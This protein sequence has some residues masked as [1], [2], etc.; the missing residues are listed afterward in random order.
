MNNDIQNNQVTEDT[1]IIPQTPTDY[2][3]PKDQQMMTQKLETVNADQ[4]ASNIPA[5]PAP[6]VETQ[7]IPSPPSAPSIDD[8]NVVA[9]INTTT[10]A[11]PTMDLSHVDLN[12]N[13]NAQSLDLT[14]QSGTKEGITMTGKT[15]TKKKVKLV[16]I[17]II[18]VLILGLTGGG[19]YFYISQFKSYDKR[20]DAVVDRAFTS[21]NNTTNYKI[22]DGSGNYTFSYN[23]SKNEDLFVLEANG[24]YA[25]NLP[26]KQVDLITN[27]TK[28]TDNQDLLPSE[29]QTEIYLKNNQ[30]Y[31]LSDFNNSYIY[32]DINESYN[33]IQD[34][35]SRF[36]SPEELLL[37]KVTNLLFESGLKD[38]S[39]N[40]DTYITNISK[41]ENVDYK[42]IINGVK[43]ATKTA[44]KSAPITQSLE[45]T[46]NVVTISIK[47]VENQ[48]KVDKA[49]VEALHNNSKAFEQLV[50]ITGIEDGKLYKELID[51]LEKKE[52]KELANNIVIKSN[53]FKSTLVSLTIPYTSMDESR[54]LSITPVGTGYR[55]VIKN[56]SKE[57]ANIKYSK[58]S[59][60]TSTTETKNYKAEGYIYNEFTV[61]NLNVSLEVVKDVT[62]SKD[63]P[64]TKDSIDYKVLTVDDFNATAAK[65][66]SFGNLGVLFKSHYKGSAQ[67]EGEPI[68]EVP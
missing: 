42:A 41:N 31:F 24:K 14:M 40:Y 43:A 68:N 50:I 19:I 49:F 17:I 12:A 54:V 59:S 47:S 65:I 58:S 36:N 1:S 38:F 3:L 56:S 2:V 7:N 8:Q 13:A 30:V 22:N 53:M 23:S 46:T 45:G 35:E 48:K 9:T 28:Y 37:F 60:K 32:T 25:Y 51:K 21:L 62:P 67:A 57:L 63:Y 64:I 5:P 4:A 11:P 39:D 66:E 55:F 15:K 33:T 6:P 26:G 27:F 20:I 10:V 52:Y 61:T 18:I 16:P 44:L 34:I 29:L